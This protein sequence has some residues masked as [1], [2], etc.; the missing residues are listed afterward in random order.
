MLAHPWVNLDI[1][2]DK[3]FLEFKLSNNKPER[4]S[5]QFKKNG[6]GLN[7]VKKRL[8]LLYPTNHS[9]TIS[10]TE[11]SYDVFLRVALNEARDRK[12]GEGVIQTNGAY[13]LA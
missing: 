9:L 1:F 13:E 4:S 6:I 3:D 12:R 7:N 11:M 5:E 10:E 2:I 8:H